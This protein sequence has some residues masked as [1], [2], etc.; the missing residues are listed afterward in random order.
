VNKATRGVDPDYGGSPYS[1][2]NA[3]M[4][5]SRAALIAGYTP[6]KMP[7]VAEKATEITIH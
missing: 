5:E 4:G 1:A 6:K 2:R 3:S 7:M